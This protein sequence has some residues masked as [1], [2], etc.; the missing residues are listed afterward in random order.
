[1]EV[2]AGEGLRKD[3]HVLAVDHPDLF[4]HGVPEEVVEGDVRGTEETSLG[5]EVNAILGPSGPTR[6]GLSRDQYEGG[7]SDKRTLF[8]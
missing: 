4:G 5:L 6:Q 2:E 8:T 7:Q 1:V 3:V